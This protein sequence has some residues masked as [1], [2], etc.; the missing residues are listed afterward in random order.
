MNW[1][2]GAHSLKRVNKSRLLRIEPGYAH[3]MCGSGFTQMFRP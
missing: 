3:R 1:K 2:T